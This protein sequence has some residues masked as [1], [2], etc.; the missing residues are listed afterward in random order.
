MRI[1]RFAIFILVA[2]ALEFYVCI[3]NCKWVQSVHK[4]WAKDTNHKQPLST[5]RP[6]LLTCND[7]GKHIAGSSDLTLQHWSEKRSHLT[8]LHRLYT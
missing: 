4:T 1:A 2:H 6:Y 7:K 5:L 3:V 8:Q